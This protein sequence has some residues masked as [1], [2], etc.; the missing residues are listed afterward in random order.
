MNHLE[1]LLIRHGETEW[2]VQRRYQGHTDVPLSEVGMQQAQALAERLLSLRERTTLVYSSDLLRARQTAALACPWAEPRYDPRL[3]ELKFGD[4]EGWTYDENLTRFGPRFADWIATPLI[5]PPPGG[6]TIDDLEARLDKWLSEL[7]DT[8]CVI[9]FT[10]GGVLRTLASRVNGT[11]FDSALRIPPASA[12][13]L[14]YDAQRKPVG[15]AEW[16][17]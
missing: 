3:R 6:E 10:H 7:P 16:L 4:F 11:R 8:G 17:S 9:A 2:N 15:G 13:W 5:A 1:V 14:R 12:V